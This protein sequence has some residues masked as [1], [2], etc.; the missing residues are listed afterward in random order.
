MKNFI[1]SVTLACLIIGAYSCSDDVPNDYSI[2]V[3]NGTI[4]Q[5]IFPFTSQ[6]VQRGI[7]L[8]MGGPWQAELVKSTYGENDWI[9]LWNNY[10]DKA[11]HYN[12]GLTLQVNETGDDRRAT[13]MLTCGETQQV[14]YIIQRT[15]PDTEPVEDENTWYGSKTANMLVSY[16]NPK[17]SLSLVV[18]GDVTIT[19]K[20]ITSGV[21]MERRVS[22][23]YGYAT[24]KP[25]V[26]TTNV[27][28]MSAP[29]TLEVK[30]TRSGMQSETITL[31]TSP[32][33]NFFTIQFSGQKYL[34][35]GEKVELYV[36]YTGY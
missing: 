13:V 14:A 1:S 24:Y 26:G 21:V 17:E 7:V 12:V 15:S 8:T 6:K 22:Y 16:D 20:L 2:K 23:S 29:R 30:S 4:N 32:Q 36:S 35:A 34:A 10:G 5:I 18:K 27:I 28:T 9:E 31:S 11:G 19:G 25:G 3:E 33:L